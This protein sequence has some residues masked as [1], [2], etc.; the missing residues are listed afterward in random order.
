MLS[1]VEWVKH[2]D[3]GFQVNNTWDYENKEWIGPGRLVLEPTMQERILE[4]CLTPVDGVLPYTTIV[5]STP[6]KNGKSTIAAAVAAWAADEFEEYSEI[7]ICAN[8]KEQGKGRIYADAK[9]HAE[10][11]ERHDFV[12]T[13]ADT[14]RYQNGTFIQA[15]AKNARTAAGSRHAVTLWDELWGYS[16]DADLEMWAE[17]TPIPTVPVSIRFI[18][19]YAGH[20]NESDLLWDIYRRN[21]GS[22]EFVEGEGQKIPGLED[23]PCWRNG[24]TFVYWDHENRMPWVTEEYLD[25]QLNQPGFR[26]SD[27]MRLHENRWVQSTE[28][29]IPRELWQ[30]ATSYHKQSALDWMNHPYR[31]YD[32][33]V[34][35]D[36]APKHD[37]TAVVGIAGDP[38]TGRTVGVFH[39]IWKPIE[40]IDFDFETTV[41]AFL[42]DV[43]NRFRIVSIRHDPAHLHQTMVRLKARGMPIEE[44]SQADGNMIPASQALFDSLKNNTLEMYPAEDFEAHM[45]AAVAE[46]KERGYRIVK[47][48][49]RAKPVDAAVALAIANYEAIR[50]NSGVITEPV[51]VRSAFGDRTAWVEVDEFEKLLPEELRG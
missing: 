1:F 20:E 19:T 8:A 23:L 37:S 7:F 10:H 34:A 30:R 49:K 22:E 18:A 42:I 35:I 11:H 44:F 25:G 28:A 41:E 26:A 45:M 39:K 12:A 15:I 47:K 6:K 36:A 2:K 13:T 24:K 21:V 38:K 48:H 32:I 51:V 17:M 4:H 50:R 33:C 3:K 27:Y 43:Y 40:G 14:I 5:Y 29:F 16:S 9:Y 46:T 31:N